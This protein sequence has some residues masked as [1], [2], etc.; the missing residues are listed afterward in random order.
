MSGAGH[1]RKCRPNR[2]CAAAD[3]PLHSSGEQNKNIMAASGPAARGPAERVDNADRARI[4]LAG[5]GP[6]TTVAISLANGACHGGK[7]Q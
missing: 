4:V 6:G 2:L 7:R 3:G 1:K 5:A